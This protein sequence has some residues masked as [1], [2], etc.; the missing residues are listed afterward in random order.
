MTCDALS[1]KRAKINT[2][3][4]LVGSQCRTPGENKYGC[5]GKGNGVS[6]LWGVSYSAFVYY[7]IEDRSVFRSAGF[8]TMRQ[9]YNLFSKALYCYGISKIKFIYSSSF[10][11]HFLDFLSLEKHYG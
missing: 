9:E 11:S 7:S 5:Y 10:P 2:G 1:A 8:A 6:G 4:H 3:R